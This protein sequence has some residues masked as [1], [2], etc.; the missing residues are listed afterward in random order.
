[1]SNLTTSLL[2]IGWARE[3][4]FGIFDLIAIGRIGESAET[5]IALQGGNREFIC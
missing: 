1:M 5:F 3:S 4:A 2:G